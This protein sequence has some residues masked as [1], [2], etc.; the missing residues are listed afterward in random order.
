MKRREFCK[1]GIQLGLGAGA[2]L[3]F[4]RPIPSFA[5]N[6]A[7]KSTAI[8]LVAIKGG[9]PDAMFNRAVASLG[10]MK[11]FVKPNQTVVVKPNIGWNVEPER[12]GN[13]NPVLVKA[14][15]KQCLDAGAK[16]VYVFDNTC[17][18]WS[19][20]YVNSGIEDAVKDAGGK[21]VPGNREDIIKVS[22]YQAAKP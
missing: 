5:A 3:A 6:T 15:I 21:M 19:S 20:C 1:K 18:R 13:T 11:N 9:E 8:D 14:I 7:A 12:A 16:D 10:G 22:R 17:D 4:G 2:Y